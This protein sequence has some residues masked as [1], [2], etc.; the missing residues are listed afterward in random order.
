M[1]LENFS[2]ATTNGQLDQQHLFLV[3]FLFVI[4]QNGIESIDEED[5]EEERRH[6]DEEEPE[7]GEGRVRLGGGFL[8]TT[9]S[10]ANAMLSP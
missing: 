9:T 3:K 10:S 7:E 4:Y 5:Q 2:Q 6:Q 8:C 1:S